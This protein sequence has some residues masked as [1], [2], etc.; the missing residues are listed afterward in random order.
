MNSGFLGKRIIFVFAAFAIFLQMVFLFAVKYDSSATT[1]II[2]GVDAVTKIYGIPISS[3]ME[4][5]GS[6]YIETTVT[7]LIMDARNL[8]KVNFYFHDPGSMTTI[9]IPA[10]KNILDSGV[11]WS[12]SLYGYNLTNKTYKFYVKAFYGI[13]FLYAYESAKYDITVNKLIVNFTEDYST[14]AISG[15]KII[16][17]DTNKDLNPG[18]GDS[19]SMNVQNSKGE[20][21]GS[22]IGT[23]DPKIAN[24]FYFTWNVS[25][26]SSGSYT[27][28]IMAYKIMDGDT[29]QKSAI[30]TVTN[31]PIISMNAHIQDVSASGTSISGTKNLFVSSEPWGYD[32]TEV[33]G[34]IKQNG[35]DKSSVVLTKYT[36]DWKGSIDTTLFANGNNYSFCVTGNYLSMPYD[37]C[38]YSFS[39]NNVALATNP[40]F[41]ITT[42]FA[43]ISGYPSKKLLKASVVS[44]PSDYNLTS[45]MGKITDHAGL[46]VAGSPFN[47]TYQTDGSWSSEHD[48]SALSAGNYFFCAKGLY[49]SIDIPWTCS[50]S[51]LNISPA[52]P[53]LAP[54]GLM[55]NGT[56]TSASI[57]LKWTDNSTD[58]DKFNIE[59]KLQSEISYSYIAQVGANITTYADNSVTAGATYDY[60]VQ[61]C[62]SSYGCSSFSEL[63][64]VGVPA[65]R[66]TIAPSMPSSLAMTKNTYNEVDLSWT[67]STDNVSVTGYEIWRSADKVTWS[68]I[69]QSSSFAYADATVSSSNPYYYKVV[70]YDASG[71]KSP[72]TAPLSLNT[73]TPP[74]I[75]SFN[76]SLSASDVYGYPSKKILKVISS[77]IPAGYTPTSVTGKIKDS[78][79]IIIGSVFNL[80][81][82]TSGGYWSYEYDASGLS[83]TYA[84]CASGMH[85]KTSIPWSCKYSAFTAT[86]EITP[87]E[88][89]LEISF[90]DVP[91]MPLKG[92]NKIF[93]KTSIAPDS[94]V[95]K[96]QRESGS[97][98]YPDTVKTDS[99]NYYFS[100]KTAEYID[101]NYT[102]YATAKKGT[103]EKTASI[104]AVLSNYA[105]PVEIKPAPE[106]LSIRFT[107]IPA[108]PLSKEKYI[109]VSANQK[110]D[111][112]KFKLE[113]TK[114]AEIAGIFS[115]AT[116][117]Y[118]L[119]RTTDFPDGSYN[120][121]A[122]ATSGTN[123]KE[124]IIAVS[125]LNFTAS[126]EPVSPVQPPSPIPAAEEFY[127]PQECKDNG[128]STPE[129]CQKYMEIPSECRAKN[130]TDASA[131]KTY[132]YQFGMPAQCI[133]QGIQTTEECQ[134]IILISSM[135]QQCKN[136]GAATK[137]ECDKIMNVEYMLTSECKSANITAAD[138]CNDYMIKN[139]SS[140]ECKNASSM[141][142][143]NY[144]LRNSFNNTPV[145]HFES[146]S[147]VNFLQPSADDF[148]AECKAANIVSME[149]CK[150]YL[151]KNLLPAECRDANATTNGDCEKI[152]FKKYGPKE[153]ID[154]QIFEQSECEKFLFK[155][156]APEDC[157]RAGIFNPEACKKHMYEKYSGKDN[158]FNEK[159]P[160]ECQKANATTS[161]TCEKVMKK[162]YMPKECKDKGIDEE[163]KC[164][165][166]LQKKYMPKECRDAGASTAAECDKIIFKKYS[167]KECEKAGID[168]EEECQKYMFNL[169]APKVK[170]DNIEDWQCKKSIEEKHLGS[171]VA[172]QTAFE[173]IK[174][175][176]S[177]MAGKAVKVMELQ[178]TKGF[179]DNGMIPVSDSNVSLKIIP[180]TEN[181]VLN[182]EN[183]LIQTSPIA[184]VVD[185][186][187]DGLSDDMEEL[188]G[189][190]SLKPDTDQDGYD[191]AAEVRTGHNPL[192]QGYLAKQLSA[193]EKAMIENKTLE[194]PKTSGEISEILSIN[195]VNNLSNV[196][197]KDKSGYIL[198]GKGEIGSVVTLYVYSDMP[199]I[200]TV[201]TNEM[202]NWEYKLDKPL[203][204]GEHEIYVVVNDETGKVVKKSN[205]SSMFIKEAKAVSASEF[206]SES[207]NALKEKTSD[208]KSSSR[209]DSIFFF[210]IAAGLS[211]FGIILI[212]R[213][214]RKLASQNISKNNK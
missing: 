188:L 27:L 174:K 106:P 77:S 14:A 213:K 183:T 23:K 155:K 209:Y 36:G 8:E 43:D 115:S 25:T 129:S 94:V 204:D 91:K 44:S 194:H 212:L 1:Q 181:I 151:A 18:S 178:K 99:N 42:S 179:E 24:R 33:V 185:T 146:G 81:Y 78:T 169:Y 186:D 110:I 67:A 127:F 97:N 39:I 112:C 9:E 89:P 90:I 55:I 158:V 117:C 20:H 73:P 152:M 60:R 86:T 56:P 38:S 206:L 163:T 111:S 140:P 201:K 61:A 45:A 189:T 124:E 74:A 207:E 198:S 135:P 21:I 187:A 203:S 148:P 52:L 176:S 200:F 32:F 82:Q 5:K 37:G 122:V 172:K 28:Q 41:T 196:E 16:Y 7:P 6:E 76:F 29:A 116:E 113:G 19:I 134:K 104:G 66:D 160:V 193:I 197:G 58:E 128:Y 192:G 62:K 202:G 72:A 166:Y 162:T 80:S 83:G 119:L 92:D 150:A 10:N 153:C 165:D 118:F 171:V 98:A 26:Y 84:F 79:G 182:E 17:A 139:F 68:M 214:K 40:T 102:I 205:P 93:V 3:G 103:D 161:E 131:C 53:P 167:P 47:L 141:E 210:S 54:S 177:E 57:T 63:K 64:T 143:C 105:T 156:Y 100:W 13:D 59:R 157:K 120:I 69:G 154:A 170:C 132:M 12:M 114:T 145:L 149:D 88:P 123:I 121:R 184:F 130:I 173:E 159:F 142:E 168:N 46:T 199:L 191:D 50:I 190:D 2:S 4:I 65:S 71:N 107:E 101:G 133:E 70:A 208:Q 125:F 109:Y 51:T 126:T 30:V 144:A 175:S 31:A 96:L 49:N 211:V 137:E 35:I 34:K 22:F 15:T 195:S 95:F 164:E 147:A 85:D 87:K 48:T 138:A 75:A 136:A 108:Y 180:A 11:T